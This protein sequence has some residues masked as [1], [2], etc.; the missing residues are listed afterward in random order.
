MAFLASYI[1]YGILIY[2]VVRNVA[3]F[4]WSASNV[5]LALWGALAVTIAFLAHLLLPA[6]WAVAIGAIL[7]LL[8]GLIVSKPS[9]TWLAWKGSTGICKNWESAFY[10]GRTRGGRRILTEQAM[11]DVKFSLSQGKPAARS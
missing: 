6:L 10:S 5:R 2:A 3:G 8:M 7:T 1:V 11:S 4:R 9:G